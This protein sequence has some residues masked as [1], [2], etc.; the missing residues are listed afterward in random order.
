MFT[1]PSASIKGNPAI[2]WGI[3]IVAMI[4]VFLL[5][6]LASSITQRRAET[7]RL[8]DNQRVA[9]AEF[10]TRS[11]RW[12]ENFPREHDTWLQTMRTDFSSKHLGNVQE[13]TLDQRPD[14][15]VLWAGY[16]FAKDYS[17]PRGHMYA[18]DD[19]RVSLRTGTPALDT[20]DGPQPAT[21]WSCKTFDVQRM[22]HQFSEGGKVDGI[23]AF[24]EKQWGEL[25]PE[26]VNPIGCGNCHNPETMSLQVVQP[27]LIQAFERRGENI[28]NATTQEMRSLVCAQCHVE[29][30]FAPPSRTLTFPWN[31]GFT[32][33]DM[34]AYYD[35]PKVTHVDWVH[36]L[37]RAPM[38]KAQHPDYELFLLGT[39]G[40]RGVSCADCHM[41]YISEGG[42]KVSDHHIMS[43]L[44]N[45]S[46]TCGT[47]H[48]DSEDNLRTYVETYQDKLLEL[49][50]RVEPEL[51]RAHIMAKIAWDE[52]ATEAQMAHVL[53][54]IRQAG[55]RWDFAV[56]SHGA[57]FHAPVETQRI[58]ANALDRSMQAQLELQR[59]LFDLGVKDV[60]MPDISTRELASEYIGINLQAERDRKAQWVSTVVPQWLERAQQ[61]GRLDPDVPNTTSLR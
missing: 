18:I 23:T 28:S 60:Q 55:W 21:C 61:A 5:G 7:T 12:G 14:M 17:T 44:Q 51:V 10:E 33:E 41:P 24:F 45:I 25:G 3:F 11:D 9:V 36:A 54:L 46:T 27:A 6:L 13:S 26:M 47:C 58:L 37:S 1:R 39:H 38:L 34:E 30:Y 20:K 4:A 42:V 31:N 8:F 59:I 16:A 2:G 57:S 49:R 32:V 40:Q 43:P 15:V 29:Y 22:M 19:M 48:R 50:N 35:D 56:A 52:G 53:Q